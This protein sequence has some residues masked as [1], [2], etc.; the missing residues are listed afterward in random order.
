MANSD[1]NVSDRW[2]TNSLTEN[3]VE[4]RKWT[5]SRAEIDYLRKTHRNIVKSFSVIYNRMGCV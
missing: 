5:R 3:S 4:R 2:Q 1:A